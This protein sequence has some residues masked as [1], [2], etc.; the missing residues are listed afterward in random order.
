[1]KIR[2]T[3]GSVRFRITPS[4][5]EALER[6]QTVREE[7]A[8]GDGWSAAIFPGTATTG[9]ELKA[10]ELILHLSDADG[11]R[12]AAP[13]AEGVYFTQEGKQ[14][15]RYYIEKDFPC[16]HPR[17]SQVKEDSGETFS[18]TEEFTARKARESV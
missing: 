14:P 18:P 11:K 5:L 7:L 10:S 16:I 3:G 17:A 9:I 12:L 4:E 8:V 1:M 13:D 2:W 6:G 15:L